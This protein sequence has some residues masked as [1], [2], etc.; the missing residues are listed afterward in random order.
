MSSIAAFWA[1]AL[2]WHVVDEEPGEAAFVAPDES[3]DLPLVVLPV[4]EKKIGKNR[5]HL[6]LHSSSPEQHEKNLERLLGLGARRVDIGQ[7]DVAWTVLADPEGNE[8]CLEPASVF[9]DDTGPIGAIA[10]DAVDPPSLGRFWSK[11]SGWP[12]VDEGDWGVAL[13]SPS[14]VGPFLTLG[15]G[16]ARTAQKLAKNRL[17]LD[18]APPV[19]GD[20]QAEVERL[21]RLGATRVDIGQGEVDW[22]VMADPEGNE[23]CVLTPR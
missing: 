16:A 18:V 11:A 9:P 8:F 6:D 21:V 17:H 14:G 10:Y 1:S 19:D 7:G 20:Q 4:S 2:D 12:V 3:Y 15:G 23:F 5:I 13:R 22:V